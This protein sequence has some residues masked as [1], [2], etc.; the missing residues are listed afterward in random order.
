MAKK[1]ADAGGDDSGG[2]GEVTTAKVLGMTIAEL[3]DEARGKFEIAAEVSGVVITEVED[4][5]AAADKGVKAGDVIV[6]IAQDSVSKPDDVVSRIDEL[7]DQ[8]RK[9]ALLMLSS[10]SGELRF[11]TLRM[12]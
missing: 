4:G 6:E 11:V 12:K 7:K 10:K 3:D 1:L 2:G 5:S 8:G 9:N